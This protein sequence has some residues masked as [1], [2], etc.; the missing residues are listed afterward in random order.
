MAGASQAGLPPDTLTD[1]GGPHLPQGLIQEST[2]KEEWSFTCLWCLEKSLNTHCD[3]V[4]AVRQQIYQTQIKKC[5]WAI[6]GQAK[7]CLTDLPWTGSD[8][9]YSCFI[10]LFI[11][12]SNTHCDSVACTVT[13]I[14]SRNKSI[15][16]E[17]FERRENIPSP[18]L[19]LPPS[20]VNVKS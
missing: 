9:L 18:A 7:I 17:R 3:S 16:I 10:D 20:E 2:R 14:F 4:A 19:S 5:I 11:C 15:K 13:N 8:L 1:P 6:V 12:S